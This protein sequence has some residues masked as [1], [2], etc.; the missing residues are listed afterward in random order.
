MTS[1]LFYPDWAIAVLVI[2]L[3]P[4]V[5]ALRRWWVFPILGGC[6]GGLDA[7]IL[8]TRSTSPAASVLLIAFLVPIQAAIVGYCRNE[9]ALHFTVA[10]LWLAFVVWV[11]RALP[12]SSDTLRFSAFVLPA[13]FLF[14]LLTFV[15]YQMGNT[16]AD[17][18][19]RSTIELNGVLMFIASA[20]AYPYG[21]VSLYLLVVGTL[22]G[23]LGLWGLF[24]F[25]QKPKAVAER[26]P[27]PGPT[28]AVA[29]PPGPTASS[30]G[31][32]YCPSC[33]SDNERDSAYCR[34]CGRTLVRVPPSSAGPERSV[35]S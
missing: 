31:R 24:L 21:D 35:P 34:K 25:F 11:L 5:V 10:G 23:F 15:V 4:T 7:I 1:L 33:G 8:G 22:L 13:T 12:M 26:P 27:E 19:G 30:A 17:A 2:L 28:Q 9:T 18:R 29:A 14:L 32:Q 16:D 6:I 3:A 20:F